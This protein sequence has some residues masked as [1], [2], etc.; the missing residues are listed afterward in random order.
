MADPHRIYRWFLR[1]Y[2]ARFREEYGTPLERQ[3]VDEYRE[4]QGARPRARFWIGAV[5]DLAISIPTEIL[6]EL[7]QDVGYA[8]RVYRRRPLSTGLALMALA[9]AIGATTGVF[10]V[11]NALL[12]RSLPFRDPQRL[13]E[14][15]GFRLGTPGAAGFTPGEA[16]CRI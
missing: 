11:V 7:S 10:S 6:H 16:A 3:F 14:L 5:T 4:I 12:I 13:V 9:L 1:L 15:Q 8:V 2:P